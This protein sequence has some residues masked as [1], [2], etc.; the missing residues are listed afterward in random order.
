MIVMGYG[1]RRRFQRTF[2][3]ENSTVIVLGAPEV[4]C[5]CQNQR[6]KHQSKAGDAEQEEEVHALSLS[7]RFYKSNVCSF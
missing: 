5:L 6:N 4:E 2:F 3:G 1:L 7:S